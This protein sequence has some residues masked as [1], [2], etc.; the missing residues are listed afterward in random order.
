MIVDGQIRGGVMP[1]IGAA[2]Y[3]ESL[4]MKKGKC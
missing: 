3:E 1:G 4:T 2:L